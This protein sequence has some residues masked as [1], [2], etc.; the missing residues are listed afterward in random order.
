[1]NKNK[2]GNINNDDN[3]DVEKMV[4]ITAQKSKNH[5]IR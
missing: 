3:N 2:N 4:T 1:M 5:H